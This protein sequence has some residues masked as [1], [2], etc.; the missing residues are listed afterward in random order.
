MLRSTINW[1]SENRQ[2]RTSLKFSLIVHVTTWTWLWVTWDLAGSSATSS[3]RTTSIFFVHDI[4]HLSQFSEPEWLK[5]LFLLS[6]T[7]EWLNDINSALFRQLPISKKRFISK[8]YYLTVTT[9]A[10]ILERHYYKINRYPHA[11][12]FNIPVTDILNYIREGYAIPPV[13]IHGNNMQRIVE[14]P[15]P[16]GHDKDGRQTNIITILTD[17]GGKIITAYPGLG[18]VGS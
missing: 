11:G 6:D 3:S 5:L 16:I 8:D 17:A 18:C 15:A 1:V 14:A 12:K 10:H 9:L 4:K 2:V 13:A 7:Q